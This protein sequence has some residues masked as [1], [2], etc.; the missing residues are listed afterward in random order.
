M[1]AFRLR[2]ATPDDAGTLVDLIRGLAEY[3][4]LSH[5]ARPDAG[6]LRRQLAPEATPPL[7]AFIAE[8]EEG[9][10]LGFALY[11]YHYSTFLTAWGLYLEDLYVVPEARGQGIGFALLKRL[12][13][14]AVERGCPRLEWSVLDWNETAIRFYEKLGARPM[15]DWT[16]MRLTGP[17][18]EH[19]GRPAEPRATPAG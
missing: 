16:T 9:R 2:P 4:R 1:P 18:L 14:V 12:A 7:E 15:D 8:D 3:E 5:E 19:L 13:E 6:A 11:F 10:A 17:A